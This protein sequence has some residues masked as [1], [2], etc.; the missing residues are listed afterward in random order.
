[1]EKYC[2]AEEATVDN[3]AH[4]KF[5]LDTKVTLRICNTHCFFTETMVA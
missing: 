2:R 4:M 3:V 1:V 5:M